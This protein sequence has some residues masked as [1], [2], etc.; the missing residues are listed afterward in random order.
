MI[1]FF[2]NI[3]QNLFTGDAKGM[4]TSTDGSPDHGS[5]ARKYLLYAFGEILLIVI[6][7][8][9]ALQVTNWNAWRNDRVKEKII[10]SD[11]A[12]NLEINIE[13]FRN[14][15]N[16]LSMWNQSSDIVIQALENK[17]DYSDTLKQHFHLARL[18]KQNLF[19]SNIGYQSY[20]DIGLD[21]ITNKTLSS[22]IINLYE[23]IIPGTLSTNYMVN[24]ENT[25]WGNH[26]VQNFD[27]I[28]GEGLTPNDYKA[29]F[30]DHF[31]ISWI[32]AYKQGRLYLMETDKTLINEC[33]RV[34]SL[35]TEELK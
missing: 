21:I 34:R 15:I 33:E 3:R 19:L 17:M 10:L 16:L 23:V 20:K 2:R 24:E 9:I 18:T 5:R 27:F 28:H 26:L 14:D 22:E 35:I 7:I 8:L 31:Y 6:G 25:E 30:S 12:K 13:T 29:L 4:P 32:K 11:L 1:K